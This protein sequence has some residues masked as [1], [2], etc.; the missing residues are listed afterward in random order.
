[1]PRRPDLAAA[2]NSLRTPGAA[3]SL[4][5][6]VVLALL[7]HFFSSAGL[8]H[9]GKDRY[10]FSAAICATAP[11]TDGGSVVA[12][13]DGLPAGEHNGSCCD[14]CC[15]AA[16]PAVPAVSSG[17]VPLAGEDRPP[18]GPSAAVL[19]APR[20]APQAARAPPLYS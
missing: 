11:A 1:M 15:G 10:D 20:W 18:V 2:M 12:A 8:S 5:L 19:L 13:G 17:I 14:L 4:L 16:V 3:R 7:M 6:L 9:P